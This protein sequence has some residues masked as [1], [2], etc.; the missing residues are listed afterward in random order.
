MKVLSMLIVTGIIGFV[1]LMAFSFVLSFI[2]NDFAN[3]I[4]SFFFSNF[5]TLIF[6]CLVIGF[7]FCVIYYRNKQIK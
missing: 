6:A 3:Y 7:P 1:L 5:F 4:D 2:N